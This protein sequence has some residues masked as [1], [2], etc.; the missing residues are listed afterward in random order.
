MIQ[1]GFEFEFGHDIRL[2]LIKQVIKYHYPNNKIY[3][4][5]DQSEIFD[6]L[7]TCNFIFKIDTSVDVRE[8]KY[9]NT[10][11][12]TPVFVGKKAILD[13]F[14]KIFNILKM[15]D[16]KTDKS[17]SVHINIS[18]TENSELQKIDFGKL[19]IYVNE[20]QQLKL[21]SRSSNFYCKPCIPYKKCV[22]FIQQSKN[23]KDL[24]KRI[25]RHILISSNEHHRAI[26]LDKI[27]DNELYITEFRFIGGNYLNYF[28]KCKN[29]LNTVID[30][31]N[32]SIGK[33]KQ[34]KLSRIVH[35]FKCYYKQLD[36]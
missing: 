5:N 21:F 19:Y 20:L 25:E 23:I 35:N 36:I 18:F 22:S 9:K 33:N 4:I 29:V 12:T 32:F 8:C 10:E 7:S 2:D 11:M 16:I 31:M 26:A 14:N 30:G 6:M 15:L 13:N 1:A 27:K 24:L 34:N 28:D 3:T 17:C